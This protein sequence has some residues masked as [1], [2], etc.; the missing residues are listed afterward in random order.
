MELFLEGEKGGLHNPACI[1]SPPPT[2]GGE[3]L[4]DIEQ[5]GW[6]T[7]DFAPSRRE[8]VSCELGTLVATGVPGWG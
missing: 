2:T 3:N 4:Q 6:G 8:E 7:Q 1:H 5:T